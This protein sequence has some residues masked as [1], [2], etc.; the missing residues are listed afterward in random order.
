MRQQQTEG[1]ADGNGT[2][3]RQPRLC[4]SVAYSAHGNQSAK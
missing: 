3:L 1:A 2:K 4:F